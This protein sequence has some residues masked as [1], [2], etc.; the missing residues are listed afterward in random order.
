MRERERGDGSWCLLENSGTADV[1]WWLVPVMCWHWHW[2]PTDQEVSSQYTHTPPLLP[3][4]RTAQHSAVRGKLNWTFKSHTGGETEEQS[5]LSVSKC[6]H[7]YTV[8]RSENSTT[9]GNRYQPSQEGDLFHKAQSPHV[10]SPSS[11]SQI[12]QSNPAIHDSFL[13]SSW[14]SLVA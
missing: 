3:P 1:G 10:T 12:K 5:V 2:W 14:L 9:P 7:H 13:F 4:P 8:R 11:P 6:W